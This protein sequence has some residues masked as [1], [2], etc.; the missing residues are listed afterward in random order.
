MQFP[1]DLAQETNSIVT[2]LQVESKKVRVRC[3]FNY[4]FFLMTYCALQDTQ[5]NLQELK[6][7]NDN[8]SMQVS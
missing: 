6:T 8:L 5:N 3:T 2:E 4:F 1:L 7:V